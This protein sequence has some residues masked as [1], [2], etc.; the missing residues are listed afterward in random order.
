MARSPSGVSVITRRDN[1]RQLFQCCFERPEAVRESF[2]R[3]YP[4]RRDTMHARF[5]SQDDELLLYVE[6]KRIMRAIKGRVGA[7]DGP[8]PHLAS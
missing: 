4:I 2:Q 1:W 7:G 8:P 6:V 5:V 3:L